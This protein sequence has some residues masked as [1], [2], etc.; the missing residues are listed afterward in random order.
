MIRKFGLIAAVAVMAVATTGDLSAAEKKY[1]PGVTDTEIKLGQTVPYSGP[2]SAFSSYGRVMTGYFKMVNEAGG[3]NGRKIN[4]ISL[5]NA[6][7]PPKAIE[8]TRKLVENDE[9]LADV[10]TVGT[11]PNVAIQKY[12]NGAK[13]PH[14]FVSAGGRRFADPQNFPWT[15]PMYP[16]FEMEGKTFGQYILKHKPAAK[17]GVLYQNDDYGKDFLVGL[18]AGLGDKIKIVAEVTYEIT[19]PTI[20]SQI[21]RLKDSGADT[22]LYFSTPKF[23]A[24]GLRK[25]KETGWTPL[26]FLA[27]PTNSVK[28]VLEPAGFDNAQGIITTQFT[29]QAGDPAWADDAEVK[30]YVEFMKK[31][32]PNDN[33]G[34]FVALSGYVNVQGIVKAITKCGDDLTRENLL[35]QATNMKGTRLKMMLPGIQLNTTPQDYAPYE[36][37]RMAKFE[38]SSWKLIDEVGT[39][40]SAK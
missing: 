5:D 20:D 15:V 9:V 3:I 25:V 34:D 36:S 27:S 28:T 7:S 19:E 32:A 8:Q 33:P 14:I 30:E 26:Q 10:G 24:Q 37:L 16:G 40:A 18:K 39:S 31:W 1:G 38:G 35:K 22:L 21:V 2:A 6:F 11:T 23:T 13:V 17:I 29:K 12:L 4:M